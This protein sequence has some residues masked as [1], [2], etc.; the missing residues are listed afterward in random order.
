M[1]DVPYFRWLWRYSRPD[2]I[3]M[4][5]ETCALCSRSKASD[6]KKG[7]GDVFA[8]VEWGHSFQIGGTIFNAHVTGW[9]RYVE[10]DIWTDAVIIVFGPPGANNPTHPFIG[11]ANP[12][13]DNMKAF[14]NQYFS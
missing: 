13:S 7:A 5:F 10:S 1:H 14:L 12:P 9:K 2:S 11:I 4:D 3:S 6:G 8:C